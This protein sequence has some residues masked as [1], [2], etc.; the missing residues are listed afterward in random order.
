VRRRC[1]HCLR[2][3]ALLSAHGRSHSQDRRQDR[4]G[5][6]RHSR[7]RW[8]PRLWHGLG[9]RLIVGRSASRPLYPSDRSANGRGAANHR[10]G[11]LRH[12]GELGRG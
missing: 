12:R 6:G 9:R 4:Q 1:R 8:G 10:I 3:P 11:S 7:A 2:R 5:R